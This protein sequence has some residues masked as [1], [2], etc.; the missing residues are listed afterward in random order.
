MNLRNLC[1][2]AVCICVLGA[3]G[4]APPAPTAPPPTSG[5]VEPQPVGSGAT[6]SRGDGTHTADATPGADSTSAADSASAPRGAG[7][8]TAQAATPGP[9]PDPGSVTI[10]IVYDNTSTDPGL[11]ADWGFACV[12]ETPGSTILFDTGAS[13][14]ILLHNL[15]ALGISPADVDAVV[16][17]HAH[18][19][20]HGGL[21]DFLLENGE[22]T[23]FA[24][25][26][27]PEG[28]RNSIA[29]G[30]TAVE[31]ITAGRE[32]FPG[33]AVTGELPGSP[34]EQA[35][36][37][38]TPGGV[39]VMTGCAHPGVVAI[40]DAARVLVGRDVDLVVGGFHMGG[41]AAGEVVE[42]ARDLQERGVRRVCPA[43]CTGEAAMRT[44]AASFGEGFISAG[45]GA[46]IRM[47]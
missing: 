33:V 45:V 28:M 16:I 23:V 46:V 47:P 17:S 9:V 8:T 37:L 19:D 6:L 42:V 12:I 13:G 11:R 38:E 2:F 25:A 21:R 10:T 29:E 22:V 44:L 18:S 41:F 3:A 14:P 1:G 7:G 5:G 43:H 35:L 15:R 24:P 32:L 30:G 4:C 36:V 40:V 20:H 31:V 39:V 27:L 26:S 34:P